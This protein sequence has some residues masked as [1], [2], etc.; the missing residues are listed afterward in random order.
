MSPAVR[1]LLL[2]LDGT[3]VD[4]EPLQREGYRRCFAARGWPLPD[5][6]LFTG[7]RAEDVLPTLDGPWRDHDP[8]EVAR[9]VTAMVPRDVAPDAVPGAPDLIRTA[10]ARGVLVAVVTSAGPAWV[11]QA[12]GDGLGLLDLVDVVVT[13]DDVVDGKPHPA[14][15]LLACERLG[16]PPD[17]TLAAE[18]SVA[19]VAAA[20]GAGVGHVVG[21]TT[22]RP[23]EELL[24]AG[25]HA[26][27]A[28]LRPVV[29]RLTEQ[30]P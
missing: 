24:A 14:G 8:A 29:A 5:L 27:Y 17:T 1:A 19:G 20:V 21:V 3:L 15:Y 7:R 12:V 2:D 22:S 4:S 6:S 11:R 16:L 9:E 30:R 23:G 10:A 26:A 25:A 28:D 18:D 13:A